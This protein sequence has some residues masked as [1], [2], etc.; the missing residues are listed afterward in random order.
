MKIF[1][2]IR[3]HSKA[4][5]FVVSLLTLFGIYMFFSLPVS[6]FPNITF[7]RIVVIADNGEEPADKV[8]VTITK[9]LEETINSLPDV[10][11][12]RST[13]SRG[14][15]QISINFQWGTNIIQS[16]Q[17]L[18]G[19]ISQIRNQLPSTASIRV[20][21]MNATFFPIIGY[22]LT[23]D[24]VSLIKMRD[25]ALYTMRPEISRIKGVSTVRVTGGD[26]KE[27]LVKVDPE[28]LHSYGL[29]I[30]QISDTL[31]KT[32][33]V[34]SIGLMDANYHLYMTLID[35]TY[36]SIDEIKNTVIASNK[37]SPVFLSDVANV[38]D[39]IQVRNIRVTANGKRAVLIN[40]SKAARRKHCSDCIRSQESV[41]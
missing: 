1:S 6:I 25:L 2:F 27:F 33:L 8:M 31:S 41:V 13:T 30:Q 12:I 24:N 3:V 16:Q 40:I 17:L 39:S 9:P 4:I 38:T 26:V 10:T 23:S 7:P 18:E 15:A 14:S 11:D 34:N 21:R 19:K 5:F 32:N 29:S 28:R 36:K 35:N 22:A 20:Q 37:I